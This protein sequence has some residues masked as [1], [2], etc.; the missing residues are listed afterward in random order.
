MGDRANVKVVETGGGELY[1]YTHWTGY[2]LQTTLAKALDRGRD[3]WD[4]ES[5]LSRIIFSEMIKDTD[6]DENVGY[7]ISTYKTDSNYDDLVVDTARQLVEDRDGEILSF[8]N[9]I[10][11]YIVVLNNY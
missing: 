3:R 9:F 5:Y 7:G 1:F 11:K 4:D 6:L 10:N 8:E 2:N